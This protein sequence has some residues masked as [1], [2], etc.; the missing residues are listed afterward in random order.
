MAVR[1]RRHIHPSQARLPGLLLAV[2]LLAATPP[3][4]AR[5]LLAR[6]SAA[7]PT[8]DRTVLA[9]ALQ[10]RDC[11]RAADVAGAGADRL[12][13]IDYTLP[14]TEKRLWV[15]DLGKATLLHAEHVAHGR[16]SGDNIAARFS[17]VEGSFQ[18]SLG[19]FATAETYI[20]ENGYSLRMDGLEPGVNDA[21]RERLVVMHGADYVDPAQARRQGRLG[22]SWGCPAVRAGVARAVIDNL[23]D[24]Q[25]LFAYARDAAWLNGSRFLHCARAERKARA[26]R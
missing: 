5:D 20:G 17:N 12:A 18:S 8:L 21:A 23:R 26:A 9:L 14:S 2:L 24:G 10:A 19:L 16:G 1:S 6:L 7:A 4:H 11:A 3:A 25:L 22:R 13:V 15:F